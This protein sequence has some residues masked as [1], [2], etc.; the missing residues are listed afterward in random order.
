M[1]HTPK[2]NSSYKLKEDA[3]VPLESIHVTNANLTDELAKEILKD[4]RNVRY[5][6]VI[7]DS[8]AKKIADNSNSDKIKVFSDNEFGDNKAPKVESKPKGKGKSG[9][10]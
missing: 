1:K 3:V 8:Q 4:Q 2:V 5:F 9:K 10:K 7:P 6:E